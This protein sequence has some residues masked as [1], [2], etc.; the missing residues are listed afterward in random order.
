MAQDVLRDNFVQ[1][2]IDPSLNFFDG[3]CRV[4]VEGQM[5]ADGDATPDVLRP[6]PTNRNI[7]DLFG[8]GSILSETLK[9]M[10]CQCPNNAEYFVIPRAD[11]AG[12]VAATKTITI[13]GSATTDGRLEIF[14]LDGKY[15][16]DILVE[17]GQSAAQIAAAIAAEY[18]AEFGDTFP[19]DVTSALGVVTYTAKNTGTVGNYLNIVPNWRGNPDYPPKGVTLTIASAVTGTGDIDPLNYQTVLGECCYSCFALLGSGS[20]YQEGW[21]E[22]LETLWDCKTPQCFGHGYTFNA[23]T[24][25]QILP[26]STNAAVFSRVAHGL[27][28]LSPPYFKAGAYAAL[29][30]CTACDNPELSIQGQQ[31]GVLTCLNIP[32]NC[33]SS[34][35]FEEQLQLKEA[36]FV[37]TGALQNGS[38]AYTSPYIFN[39]VTNYL[40]DENLR[41]NATFRDTNSRRLAAATAIEVGTV[42]QEFSGLGLF[43]KNTKIRQGVKGT[44]PRLVLAKMRAWAKTQIGALF[45]E[46]E[47]IDNDIQLKTDAEVA[48]QCQG[49]PGKLHLLFKYRPPVRISQIVAN[50]QPSL[51]LNCNR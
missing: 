34:F 32:E 21:Q 23:G 29:S 44:N 39:D 26:R 41:P 4:L 51:L 49:Q 42:L 19:Y 6:L 37:V 38:G 28:D 1:L 14:A 46:F 13:T 15:N 5:L 33:A 12:G 40:Y 9:L 8:L 24:L 48:P 45:S 25:G 36:G 30:C 43:T 20:D 2:C 7:D 35:S 16:V 31:Y 10:F 22:Y 50:L 11:P 18:L 3:K 17:T 27:A 47:N